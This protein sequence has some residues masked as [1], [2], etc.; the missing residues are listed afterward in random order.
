[1]WPSRRRRDACQVA[2][3]HG[4]GG[5]VLVGLNPD[6]EGHHEVVTQEVDGLFGEE[7]EYLR[8]NHVEVIDAAIKALTITR[9]GLLQ[10]QGGAA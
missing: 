3:P 6:G 1:M 9:D 7:R 2:L 10:A 5:Y 4:K 8:R